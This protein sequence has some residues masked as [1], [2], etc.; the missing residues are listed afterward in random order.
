LETRALFGSIWIIISLCIWRWSALVEV[1]AFDEVAEIS[2]IVQLDEPVAKPS[3]ISPL[4]E[5]GVDKI[6][7]G[8]MEG[9][10]GSNGQGIQDLPR[11]TPESCYTFEAL[12]DNFVRTWMV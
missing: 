2:K 1:S 5:W 8:C 3:G 12:K 7:S 10:G 11:S 9:T 4:A 6:S